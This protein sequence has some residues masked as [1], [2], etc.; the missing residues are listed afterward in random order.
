MR[1]SMMMLEYWQLCEAKPEN[2][3]RLGR[4]IGLKVEHASDKQVL[5]RVWRRLVAMGDASPWL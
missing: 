5:Y 1:S 2:L 4:A 3:R